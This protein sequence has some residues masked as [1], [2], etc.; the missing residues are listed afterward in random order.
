MSV[1]LGRPVGLRDE[2][3]DVSLPSVLDHE[4]MATNGAQ[5]PNYTSPFL[6]VIAIRKLAGKIL[7]SVNCTP[8]NRNMSDHQRLAIRQSLHDELDAWKTEIPRV[9]LNSP[10]P[11]MRPSSSFL[12]AAWYEIPYHNALLLLYRPSPLFPTTSAPTDGRSGE[13]RAALDQIFNSSKSV[14]H[15][16]ADLHRTRRLNYSWITLHAVFMA[17]LAYVY[18]ISRMIKEGFRA[19]GGVPVCM[20]YT[21]IIAD[22]RACSNV[23]VAINERW[24][25][26]R[27]SCEIFERLS[28]ALIQDA[29][30]VRL[31][32]NQIQHST[33]AQTYNSGIMGGLAHSMNPHDASTQVGDPGHVPR[34]FMPNTSSTRRPNV[35]NSPPENHQLSAAVGF[36][37]FYQ[38]LQGGPLGSLQYDYEMVPSEVITGFSHDWFEGESV[39]EFSN[40]SDM[41]DLWQ[42]IGATNSF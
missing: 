28:T 3:I 19:G 30:K 35:Q 24:G 31:K 41:T 37:Q 23:L 18:C 2:D 20:D 11:D 34:S 32:I 42:T 39:P 21:C 40:S 17:G 38:D 4:D 14:I 12:W 29:V 22:T 1:T 36:R 33:T 6:H 26:A 15:L 10:K 13:W 8:Q 25:A 27:G 16:Y 9:N 5:Q 7:Q